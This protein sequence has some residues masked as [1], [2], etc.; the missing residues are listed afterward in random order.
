MN[1]IFLQKDRIEKR[2]KKE[3]KWEIQLF[4][5]VLL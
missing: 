2:M 1:P 5:S 4:M 3:C